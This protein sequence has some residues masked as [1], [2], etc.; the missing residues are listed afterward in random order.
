[1]TELYG[2][3]S[4]LKHSHLKQL[5]D[6]YTRYIKPNEL[7]TTHIAKTMVQISKEI[8]RVVGIVINRQG[9]IENVCVGESNKLLLPEL[10]KGKVSSNRF[11]GLRL[12]HTRLS[13]EQLNIEDLTYLTRLRLDMVSVLTMN[14]NG[15]PDLIYSATIKPS[16]TE[17]YNYLDPITVNQ[18]NID[19]I[20][21]INNLEDSFGK[22]IDSL[23]KVTSKEN[24][25]IIYVSDANQSEID[26]SIL[27]M[28]DLCKTAGINVI[29]TIVQKKKINPKTIIGLGKLEEV[30]LSA[31]KA[32]CNLLIFN[33]SL[34]PSQLTHLT[35]AFE[36]KIIDRNMLILDIF[37]QHAKSNDGKLQV[38]L[39]Q[40][41]YSYPRLSEKTY[42]FSR[43]SGGAGLKSKGA[44][45]TKLE[46]ER[47][48]MSDK[49]ILLEKKI[50]ELS[51][52]R[53]VQRK[54]RNEN[55]LKIVS[56]V[57]YTNVGKS[58]ILNKLTKSNV[59]A[60]NKLFATL[61]ITSRSVYHNEQ[62]IIFNDTVGFIKEL[63]EELI[64]AFMATIEEIKASDVILHVVDISDRNFI[65]KMESIERI[66]YS[67]D[68]DG[69]Q[70]IPVFNKIDKIDENELEFRK[71]LYPQGIFLSAEKD[72]NTNTFLTELFK[73]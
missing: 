70:I 50:K 18:T 41:K 72:F 71:R 27:E 19:F 20:N 33:H 49:M 69:I 13:F 64:V 7:V 43:I 29:D 4:G 66:L 25:I 12:F 52:K 37:S 46:I 36:I 5:E 57:G 16:K 24:G 59:I 31:N 14:P 11:R 54:K 53:E 38:E 21:Y 58:T 51:K 67:F 9:V 3:I 55:N 40:L 1:M 48:R 73:A 30:M 32:N 17:D 61:D 56:I 23:I 10:S 6:L 44:G 68:I 8:N 65:N 60:E 2:N 15:E 39:A 62:K 42:S 34:S 26:D 47:R 22:E 63:P 28:K 45:E 35:N